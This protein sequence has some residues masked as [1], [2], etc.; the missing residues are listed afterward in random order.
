MK[1]WTFI[2][3]LWS[4]CSMAQ[5]V[6]FSQ[7]YNNPLFQSPAL[8][9][10]F[11]G[12]YR[13]TAHQRQQW[14]SVSVPFRSISAAFDM[15]YK[16]WGFG[17]QFLRDQSGSSRLSLSQLSLSVARSFID[18]QVGLQLALAQQTIDYSDLIFIDNTEQIPSLS[19]SY[20]DIGLGVYRQL[21]FG[22]KLLKVGYSLLHIN[23][24]NRSF[25]SLEDR[26]QPKH[27]FVSYLEYPLHPQWL[28]KPSIIWLRQAQQQAFSL[29]SSITYDISD[30]YFQDVRFEGGAY[31]RIGD[32]I[33]LLLGIQWDQN[34]FAFS[35][36][37]NTSD[38]IP[39]SNYLGAWELSFTHIIKS[40][41][42]RSTYTTCPAFL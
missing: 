24:P 5:D 27:Q 18:W 30:L 6:H 17:A 20:V 35:Y 33:A 31:Y 8:A 4:F 7:W 11:D 26:L 19:A 38:L 12:A 1:K 29:G 15:P 13:V 25:T 39:A 28:M 37:I 3:S 41:F 36:D 32:A 21:F 42:P 23:T 9:G 2:L 40:S 22:E 16:S 34:H 14:A 10:D